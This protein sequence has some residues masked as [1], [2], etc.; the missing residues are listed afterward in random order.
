MLT[1][2]AVLACAPHTTPAPAS[3]AA[4]ATDALPPVGYGTLHQEDVALKLA[5]ESVQLRVLPLDEH[6]TRLLAPDAYE[7]LRRLAAAHQP[8]IDSV[9]ARTG[10]RA[11]AFLV[12]FF[13]V[14]P[15]AGFSPDDVTISS[16]NRL[17]RPAA[18]LPLSP[19]WSERRLSQR[20]TASAIYLFEEGVTLSQ[21]LTV[22]YGGVSA[23]QWEGILRTLERE[24]ARIYARAREAGAGA[25]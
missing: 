5:T 14:A 6:V 13:A 1:L 22:S 12:T 24:R 25:P 18:V 4:V 11:R 17:F 16:Q 20:E 23:D 8:E 7:S 19:V 9:A 2:L 10:V 21:P 15:S 3:P